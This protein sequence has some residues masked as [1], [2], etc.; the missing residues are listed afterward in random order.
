LREALGNGVDRD[1]DLSRSFLFEKLQFYLI[2][3]ERNPELKQK[4]SRLIRRGNG[5]IHW[6]L[7]EDVSILLL[8]D[9]CDDALRKAAGV[10]ATN[11]SNFPQMVSPLW[12]IDSYRHSALQSALDYPPAGEGSQQFNRSND[13]IKP[14][15]KGAKLLSKTTSLS[16]TT[17]KVSI[18][19]GCL[20]SLARSSI[21]IE[22]KESKQVTNTNVEFDSKELEALIEA[23]GGQT[24]SA[25]LLGALH[26]DGKGTNGQTTRRK[27]YVVCWGESPTRL[28]TNPLVSQLER[29]DLCEIILVTP[30]WVKACVSSR[31]R[32]R[33]DRM[34]LALTPQSWP[35]KSAL[36]G[37]T[38][39]SNNPRRRKLQIAVTGFQGTEKVVLVHLIDAIGG[40]YRD[41]MSNANTH[42]IY[43][44]NPSGLKLEKAIEWGLHVVSVEWLYHILRYGY[45]GGY[46]DE[47]G[48]EKRF[49]FEGS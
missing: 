11:H 23:H 18:F 40:V 7:N 47:L 15:E 25:K 37:I 48:C 31:K 22:Q 26:A 45:G 34:P 6:D 16:S 24:L 10:I 30:I 9:A 12:V 29:L 39:L 8:C 43:K 3:F 36:D 5:T 42:L 14:T 17:S 21:T 19:R 28:E 13:R 27:C 46:N 2:G 35:M 33:S 4:I 49:S 44:K 20:F 38:E 41:N 32:I 1:T